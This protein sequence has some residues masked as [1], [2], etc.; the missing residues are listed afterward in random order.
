MIVML[1]SLPGRVATLSS[2]RWLSPPLLLLPTQLTSGEPP[3]SRSRNKLPDPE[4]KLQ[5]VQPQLRDEECSIKVVATIVGGYVEGMTHTAGDS[6]D[7][8]HHGVRWKGLPALPL[9]IMTPWILNDTRS[10][11]DIITCG[12]LQKLTYPGRDIVPL[13]HPILGFGGQEVNPTGMICLLLHFGDR[14]KP[15]NPKSSMCLGR[16][17]LQKVDFL[18]IAS[19]LLELQFEA[20]DGSM[21]VMQGDQ[22]TARECY[23]VSIRPLVGQA[24]ERGPNGQTQV[25]KRPKAGPTSV[26]EDLIIHTLA[27]TPPTLRVKSV[28]FPYVL[29]NSWDEM[30]KVSPKN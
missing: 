10:S 19:Y 14:L 3:S 8:S 5:P 15:R 18:A 1:Q 2:A 24:N 17:T 27:A 23:L 13:V 9:R 22:Q 7:S 12:C 26:P 29:L 11:M 21:G 28:T 4:G 30:D 25:G 6:R 16:P 20:D